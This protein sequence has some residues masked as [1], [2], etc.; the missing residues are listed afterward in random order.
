M[1]P[2]ALALGFLEKSSIAVPINAPNAKIFA[3]GKSFSEIIRP[4][5]VVP[6]LAPIMTVVA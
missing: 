1:P 3:I 6:M 5:T 4:V 2:A